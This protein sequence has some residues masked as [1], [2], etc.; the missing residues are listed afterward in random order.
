MLAEPTQRTAL[1]ERFDAVVGIDTH[2][3]RH[4]VE[5]AWPT[6]AT[7]ATCSI[8]NDDTGFA[9]LRT[10][11]SAHRPGERTPSRTR[12]RRGGSPR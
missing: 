8:T 4:Q 7:I 6:G 12:C 3:D 2:R 10:W 1:A 5:I 9:E 11:I